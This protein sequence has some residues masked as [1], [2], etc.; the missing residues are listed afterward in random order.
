MIFTIYSNEVKFDIYHFDSGIARYLTRRDTPYFSIG[1]S[2][3]VQRQAST[4]DRG[5]APA[6]NEP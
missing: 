2:K 3:A 1:V 6:Q 4:P 5:I